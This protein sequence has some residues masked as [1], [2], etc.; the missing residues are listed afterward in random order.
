MTGYWD[1]QSKNEI[2]HCLY[3]NAHITFINI[4]IAENNDHQGEMRKDQ[5]DL[6]EIW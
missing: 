1:R 5:L 4:S 3:G 6:A 2:T